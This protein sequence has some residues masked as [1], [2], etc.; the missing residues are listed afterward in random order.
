GDLGHLQTL[1]GVQAS[2]VAQRPARHAPAPLRAVRPPRPSC[3]NLRV[4]LDVAASECNLQTTQR[5]RDGG[6]R[7][8]RGNQTGGMRGAVE[9][10][11]P[12]TCSTA[13][14]ASVVLIDRPTSGSA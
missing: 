2:K 14:R 11:W 9:T 6:P 7:H 8:A 12:A 1:Q 5:Y 10:R 4:L 3:V 13:P